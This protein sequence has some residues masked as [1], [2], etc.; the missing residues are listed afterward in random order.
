MTDVR[1]CTTSNGSEIWFKNKKIHRDDGPAVVRPKDNYI[2][3][4]V[5]GKPCSIVEWFDAVGHKNLTDKELTFFL[6]KYNI[7]NSAE[8]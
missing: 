2:A 1:C 5:N 4:Y 7:S 8:Q 3:Y 6:L